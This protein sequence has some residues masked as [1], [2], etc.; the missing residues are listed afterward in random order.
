[1]IEKLK[2]LSLLDGTSFFEDVIYTTKNRLTELFGNPETNTDFPK[3]TCEWN[4]DFLG[5]PISVYDWKFAENHGRWFLDDEEITW[6]VGGRSK[7]ETNAFK[8][9]IDTVL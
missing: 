8:R 4:L 3:V 2:D 5:F 7:E 6:H 1:M 9:Y